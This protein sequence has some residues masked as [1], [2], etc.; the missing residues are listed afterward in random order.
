[1]KITVIG[2]YC[3]DL[4][5]RSD[6]TEE[7]KHGGIYHAVAALASLAADR[8]TIF[9]VFS[10]G[11][12]DL[13]FVRSA[14]APF[15]NV[16]LAGVYTISAPSNE[17]VYDDDQPNER[18]LNVPPPIPFS[19][20]KKF[21]SVDGV[22]VNMVSGQ[23]IVIDTLDEIRLQVRGKKVPIHLDFHCLTFTVNPDGTRV[24]RPMPDWRRWCFMTDSVQMN[25][26]EAAEVSAEQYSNELLAKQMIPLMVKAFL[27]TRGGNGLTLYQEEAKHLSTENI[28][29]AEPGA[30]VVSTLGSGDILGAAF[31]YAVLKKKN[32]HDAAVFAEKTAAFS[33]QFALESKHAELKVMRESL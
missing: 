14:F 17:V 31:L 21:L 6:G 28:G 30:P 29:A 22:L 19:A 20:I 12:K 11:E 27:I 10:V 23:D 4:F 7:R 16:D 24:R 33:T 1:M 26:E 18:S 3:V 13:E 2:H 15:K 5:R 8:D 25:E 9:P 32:Y